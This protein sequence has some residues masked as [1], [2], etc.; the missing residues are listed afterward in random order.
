M[1]LSIHSP[2]ELIAAIPHLLGFKVE[3]S[4]VLVPLRADLPI[5]R[6]DLPTTANERNE[7]WDAIRGAFSRYVQPGAS[8]A[9]VCMTHDQQAAELIG[10]DLAVRLASIGIAT[11][12]RL[13]ADDSHWYD[14]DSGDSGVQTEDA[15]DRLAATNVLAERAQPVNSRDAISASLAGDRE[16]VA[17]LMP[18]TREASA[19]SMQ[20]RERQWALG[21]LQQFQADG[22]R[23]TD[24]DA[25]RLLVAAESIPIRDALWNDIGRGNAT[26]HVA[27]W[28]DL[29]SRAPDEVRAAPASLLGFAA[30]Q[31]GNGAMAWCALDQVPKDKP[32]TL[33]NLVGAA[34][35]TGRHPREWE[36][37]K[38]PSTERAAEAFVAPQASAERDTTRPAMGM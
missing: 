28:T 35:Q 25:S 10:R 13:S 29:T 19:Q 5:A 22:V 11:P 15:R 38:S 27:L 6:V 33:A 37:S 18:E 26:S 36:T 30:W 17:N 3:E 2:D 32:Y 16:P 4:I 12:L 31:N 8:V 7:V 9:I 20:N 23:L 21:R 1:R 34:M 14:L 24:G